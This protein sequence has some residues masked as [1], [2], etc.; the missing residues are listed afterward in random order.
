MPLPINSLTTSPF[1]R[2]WGAYAVKAVVL[3]T[4]LAVASRVLPHMGVV[5]VGLAW[6]LLSAAAAIGVAY[7]VIMRKT[8]K[9]L[10]LQQG[11]ILSRVNSGRIITLIVSFVLSAVCV[12]G[13]FFELPKWEVG[14]WVAVCLAALAFVGVH[15]AASKFAARQYSPVFV[16]A[17]ATAWTIG[18]IG[19]LLCLAYA[20]IMQATPAVEYSSAIEA[21][22]AAEQPFMHS[23]SRLMA[24]IGMLASFLDGLTAFGLSKVASINSTAYIVWKIVLCAS[25]FF[26]IAN[27]LGTCSLQLHEVRRVFAT[28]SAADLKEGKADEKALLVKRYIAVA[29]ALPVLL[30]AAFLYAD[31]QFSAVA[32]NQEV[33]AAE[34]I[35]KDQIGVTAYVLDGKYYDQQQAQKV[36]DEFQA[37]SDELSTQAKETLVPLI[38]ASFDARVSNVDSYLDWYYSLP[39]DYERLANMVTGNVEDY[40]KD[41]LKTKLETGV[42]DSGLESIYSEYQQ[43]CEQLTSD[44]QDA[45][46]ACELTNVPDWLISAKETVDSSFF[47]KTVEPTQKFLD[48]GS[49]AA[50]SAVSGFVAGKVVSK[51][52]QKA[53]FSKIVGRVSTVIAS[54]GATTAAGAAVGSVAGP[55]GTVLGLATGTAIGVGT[56]YTL[57]KIDEAQNR[58][59][60][61]AEII[62]GIEEERSEMLALVQ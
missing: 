19:M 5:G 4:L 1:V 62:E 33:S 22:Q 9:Q 53:F 10:V 56:D 37:K 35:I 47:S 31:A 38:N 30:F 40:M 27:L 13:L 50:I 24:D 52:V 46:A 44:Y 45:L 8:A 36:M 7:P 34:Q 39:A 20:V 21:F 49:R 43:Q 11:G 3:L 41:Q 26:A 42:D 54:R 55:L 2:R 15:T 16:A 6:A 58:E 23:P 12:A 14:E 25:S 32:N 59:T 57:L 17:K 60:Y 61:K 51:V 28:L 29:V 18:I 48:S